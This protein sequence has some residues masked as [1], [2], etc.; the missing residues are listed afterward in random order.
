MDD[1]QVHSD[2]ARRKLRDLLN[3]VEHDGEHVTI[4]RYDTP[5]AVLM[6]VEWRDDLVLLR[7]ALDVSLQLD[8]TAAHKKRIVSVQDRL[9]SWLAFRACENGRPT[10]SELR[11]AIGDATDR[12]VE[13]ALSK[14]ETEKEGKP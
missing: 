10:V 9:T 2:E 7:H 5:A 4:L 3:A 13:A 6:P 8:R 12:N 1:R 11:E 14:W